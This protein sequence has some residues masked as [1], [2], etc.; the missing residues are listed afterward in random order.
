MAPLIPTPIAFKPNFSQKSPVSKMAIT[1]ASF[2]FA[3][4]M[5]SPKWSP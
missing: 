4:G 3:M 2:A 5:V 1:V